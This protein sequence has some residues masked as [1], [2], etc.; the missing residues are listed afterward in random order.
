MKLSIANDMIKKYGAQT[1]YKVACGRIKG[2]TN[3]WYSFFKM[4]N[5]ISD[6]ETVKNLAYARMTDVERAY[7]N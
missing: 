7:F 6:V 1:I 4:N 2:N 5:D 3:L